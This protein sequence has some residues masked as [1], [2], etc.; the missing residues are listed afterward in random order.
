RRPDPYVDRITIEA[1]KS[2]DIF[3]SRSILAHYVHAINADD[4]PVPEVVE[5]LRE[6]FI[7]IL[8][9]KEPGQALG[10]KKGRGRPKKNTQQRDYRF[11]R[12]VMELM[13]QGHKE[14]PAIRLV[15][16]SLKKQGVSDASPGTV[17]KAYETYAIA[18]AVSEG[19][20]YSE[21][22]K[23]WYKKTES[24]KKAAAPKK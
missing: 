16:R 12:M 2:G 19:Y 23:K 9:G 21:K 10:V 8:K 7:E 20:G 11:A 15:S 6:A 18:V 3:A 1:A 5:Y 22:L 13:I 14:E 4:S 24:K 17:K